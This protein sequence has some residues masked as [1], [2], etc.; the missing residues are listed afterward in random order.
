MVG[1]LVEVGKRAALKVGGRGSVGI[2]AIDM[3][4][5]CII[6]TSLSCKGY[7][8]CDCFEADALYV[9]GPFMVYR[10]GWD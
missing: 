3:T 8:I 2:E 6:V 4:C 7:W 10:G 9:V 1:V 5:G